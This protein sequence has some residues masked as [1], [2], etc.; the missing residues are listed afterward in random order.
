MATIKIVTLEYKMKQNGE[1]PLALRITKDRKA[2]FIPLGFSILPKHW[3]KKTS[4]VKKS[5]P[6]SS[7]FNA[8]IATKV[9]GAQEMTLDMALKSK[10]ASSD[11]IKKQIQGKGNQNFFKY[12]EKH[13]AKLAAQENIGN[14]RKYDG[15]IS[16]LKEYMKDEPLFFEK[17][18]HD[19]LNDY[20]AYLR[21]VKENS[22]NTIHAN[23]K[24][25]RKLFNDAVREKIL[26]YEKNPFLGFKM[27]SENT[28]RI[29][30][31][32]KEVIA[33][34]AVL[35]EKGSMKDHHRNLFVFACYAGGLRISDLLQLKWKNYDGERLVLF[36]KKTKT[37]ASIVLPAK[38]KEIIELY[39]PPILVEEDYIF[40]FLKSGKDYSDAKTLFN[41]ISSATAYANSNL[42]EI[43]KEAKINKSFGFHTS[44]HTFATMALNKGMRIEHV[45]KFL[46]HQSIRITQIY[47]KIVDAELD[48]AM[49]VFK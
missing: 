38:A 36:T 20:E 16:K 42:K 48:K 45:S 30:L 15:V 3:D 47:A 33:M 35:L 5:H 29:Y 4:T 32:E 28:S 14:M 12:A 11:E 7:R 34:D 23:L 24:L 18:N 8:L 17:I 44:R 49:D 22:H 27:K 31:T 25:I 26:G 10:N 46:G 1:V 39:K 40:P 21:E 41:G 9:A 19:F 2:K 6:N 37:T 43:A 13:I